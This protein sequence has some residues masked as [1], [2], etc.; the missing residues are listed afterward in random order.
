MRANQEVNPEQLTQATFDYMT[1]MA[2]TMNVSPPKKEDLNGVK[3]QTTTASRLHGTGW[4]VYSIQTTT[5]NTDSI[6]NI[7]ERIIEIK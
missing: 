7:E 3:N 4:V 2:S 5:V 1:K 6:T